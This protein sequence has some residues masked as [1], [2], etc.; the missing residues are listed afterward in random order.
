VAWADDDTVE[1]IELSRTPIVLGVQWHPE[2][3][4]DWPEQQGL[5]RQLV[6]QAHYYANGTSAVTT[7]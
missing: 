7:S 6:E 5:F 3:L 4:E 2:V 1:A